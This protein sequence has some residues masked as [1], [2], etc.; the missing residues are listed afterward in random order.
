MSGGGSGM[1]REREVS[2]EGKGMRGGER[3]GG[4]ICCCHQ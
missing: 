1:R 2:N 4:R 3:R